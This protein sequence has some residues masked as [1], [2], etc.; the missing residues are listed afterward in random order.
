MSDD[1]WSRLLCCSP[2]L[3]LPTLDAKSASRMGHPIL[4]FMLEGFRMTSCFFA[5][6]R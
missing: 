2:T 4:R 5:A 1:G 6:K 3:E